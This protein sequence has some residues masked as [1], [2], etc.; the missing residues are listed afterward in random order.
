V[1][2]FEL[3]RADGEDMAVRRLGKGPPVVCL[4]GGPG[5]DAAYLEDLAGLDRHYE[6]IIPDM[7]GTGDSAPPET[8]AGHGFDQLALD[9]EALREHLGLHQMVLLAHSAACTT[10]LVYAAASHPDRL[11]ALILVTPSRVLYTEVEDDTGAILERRT[12]EPWYPAVVAAQERLGEG[13]DADEVGELLATLAPASYARWGEREQAHAALMR[14]VSRDA[15]RLFWQA[16]V[17]GDKV[18]QGL[19]L[20][21]AP[22]LVITG[23]LDAA[24]GVNA[25]AAWAAWFPN[26]RHENIEAASHNPWVDEP[27]AFT[28]LVRGF[29]DAALPR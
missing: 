20:V 23:G 29:L 12:S 11:A 3:R 19:R 14:P 16:D 28:S 10:A 24:V 9:V 7:R 6:L 1:E 15:I 18:R 17:D 21:E 22:V 13:P 27:E 2:S 4:A 26:G 5:A 25:G 8:D